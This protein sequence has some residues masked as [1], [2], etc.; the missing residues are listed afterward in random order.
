MDLPR[1]IIPSRVSR[2]TSPQCLP[3][4]SLTPLFNTSGHPMAGIQTTAERETLALARM[5]R[6]SPG[7]WQLGLFWGL[8]SLLIA[9]HTLWTTGEILGNVFLKAAI[10]LA[11]AF[12]VRKWSILAAALLLIWHLY[13]N[14]GFFVSPRQTS[15]IL[16]LVCAIAFAWSLMGCNVRR[17]LLKK[18][19][20][21]AAERHAHVV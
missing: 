9:V 3:T 2:W 19:P 8:F 20:P 6:S 18:Y 4:F 11:L 5:M 1:R 21:K 13:S 15:N 17:Q 16:Y 12:W 10:F 14:Y 7:A